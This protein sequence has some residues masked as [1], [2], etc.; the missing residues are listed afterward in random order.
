MR[1]SRWVLACALLAAAPLVA[2]G[3][4]AP[5]HAQAAEPHASW[6]ILPWTNG[7][8]SGGYD[9]VARKVV[10]FREHVYAQRD[11]GTT[12]RELAFD[13]YFGLRAGGQNAWLNGRPVAEAGWDGRRGIARVVQTHAGVRATQYL[14]APFAVPAPVLI[15]V[16]EI[17]NTGAAPLADAALFSLANLHLGGGTGT[18][19]ERIRWQDGAFEERGARGLA[20]VRGLPAPARHAA[21][22]DN[23]YAIVVGGGRLPDTADSGVRD[24]AVSGFEW[25][26]TGL[27]PGETRRFAQVA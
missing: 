5:A 27:A 9:T 2:G 13:V 16:V 19:G 3:P 22:P 25:D 11:A 12:T 26:L 8:G 14:F 21:S 6:A 1:S 7:W 17:E 10:S 20:V 15:A 4:P 24:D 23:P 18:S